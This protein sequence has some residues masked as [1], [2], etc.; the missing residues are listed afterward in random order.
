MIAARE[1]DY[2]IETYRQL[3]ELRRDARAA[4]NLA[5]ALLWKGDTER[6]PSRPFTPLSRSTP[7]IPGRTMRNY[8]WASATPD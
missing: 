4:T 1:L 6:G 8:T 3:L 2:A 5:F 7:T